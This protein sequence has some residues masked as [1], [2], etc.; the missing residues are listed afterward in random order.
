MEQFKIGETLARRESIGRRGT[1]VRVTPNGFF[2][3]PGDRKA[4]PRS[5][6]PRG[7]GGDEFL[8]VLVTGG[9]LDIKGTRN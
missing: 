4:Q 1:V 5:A 9:C 7:G 2:V 6:G 8:R 3:A